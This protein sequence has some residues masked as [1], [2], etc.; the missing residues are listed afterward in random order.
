MNGLLIT[1]NRRFTI[2]RIF[3]RTQDWVG[4]LRQSAALLIGLLL[5]GMW[6][7]IALL[8]PMIAPYSPVEQRLSERLSPPSLSHPFGTDELGRDVFS[9]V[10]YGARISLPIGFGV[11]ALT[12]LLGTTLGAIAGFVG[13]L[14]DELIMR[15][16]DAVLAFPSLILAM[17][18]TA[19]LG[20]GLNNA[21][22]AIVLVLWPEYA[23]LMRGQVIYLREMEYVTAARAIGVPEHRIL[24]RHIL[25]NAA[26]VILVKASLDVGNAIL[27]AAA[28]SFVG[29]GA[30]PPMPEWGAMVAAARQKFF[31]WWIGT[32]PGLAILTTVVGFNFLGDGLR[33]FLDPRLR[34]G[35]R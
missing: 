9:R 29:L 32:F 17:A 19:V 21:M 14:L 26:S 35:P 34:R 10:L 27:L 11:V 23:R 7:L 30:V 6:V 18:I 5:I 28:L 2:E 3:A 16:S 33:D 25:P 20:P 13:G 1:R 12:A 8:A 15:L 22:L 4:S 24:G 31:E